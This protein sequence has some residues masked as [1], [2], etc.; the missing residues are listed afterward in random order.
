[1]KYA[2]GAVLAIVLLAAKPALAYQGITLAA[3]GSIPPYII[4][5]H[6]GS[7][8]EVIR[9][10]LLAEELLIDELMFVSNLRAMRLLKAKQVDAVINAPSGSPDIYYSE[11]VVHYQN[12]AISLRDS[13]LSINSLQ[14]LRSLKVMAFQ[15]ASRYLGPEYAQVLEG[16]NNYFE[17]VNQQAQIERLH[18][19]QVDVIVLDRE[20]YH[21]FAQKLDEQRLT[22]HPVTF[23][24]L[25]PA[26]PRVLGFHSPQ[27][28]DR[29]NRG[30]KQVQGL[31]Q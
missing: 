21:Y 31:E 30:L 20:I 8:L 25:F 15:N 11:P 28:R 26:S 14:D 18:R 3:S 1:M 10:A 27:L 22:L 5:Q 7:Q 9:D 24:E 4:E 17:V 6:N 19:Q 16:Q 12:V 29:F 2:L 13:E 23:H